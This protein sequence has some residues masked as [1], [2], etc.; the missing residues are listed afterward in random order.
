M[1][2]R[3]QSRPTPNTTPT[4]KPCVC[5]DG[6]LLTEQVDPYTYARHTP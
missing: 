3:R 5:R 2:V 6:K 1:A 4:T